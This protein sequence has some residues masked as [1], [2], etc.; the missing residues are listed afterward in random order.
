MADS[1]TKR[2]ILTGAES[3]DAKSLDKD[4]RTA[5]RGYLADQGTS[6]Y[7]VESRI[8]RVKDAPAFDVKLSYGLGRTAEEVKKHHDL[9][10][11]H[12]KREMGFPVHRR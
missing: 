6:A 3:V 7:G 5:V 10:K 12:V 4:F 1:I 11:A 9:L 8:T 2:Y